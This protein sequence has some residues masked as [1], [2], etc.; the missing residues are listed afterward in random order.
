MEISKKM[1]YALRLLAEAA[2][3][4]AGEVVSVREAAEKNDIPYSFA[5]S[6]QHELVKCGLLA[7]TRGPRGGMTLAV[8]PH[9]L[10]LLD[11]YRRIEASNRITA[12]PV[13]TPSPD[14]SFELI[15]RGA[16]HLIRAYLSSVTLY[17][18]IAEGKLPWLE[19]G[20]HFVAVPK[21]RVRWA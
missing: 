5:R 2:Q 1:N 11:V 10:T 17:E 14:D 3:V 13:G 4:D 6:I 8:N 7:T 19:D 20:Y 16:E 9:E 21:D 12:D 15:W 18:V